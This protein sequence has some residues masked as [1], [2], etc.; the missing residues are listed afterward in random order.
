M[1]YQNFA[2]ELAALPDGRYRISVSSPGGEASA[3]VASPFTDSA[4]SDVLRIL[5]REDDGVTRDEMQQAARAFGEQLFDFLFRTSTAINNAYVASL[6]RAGNEGLRI[7]LSVERA[8]VLSHLPW[9]LIR[10][11]QLEYLSLSR[12]TPVVRYT[13]QLSIRPPAAI[14][15]PLRALVMISSPHDHPPL[16]VEG[17]WTRLKGA[18]AELQRRGI[19]QLERLDNATLIDLQRR[20]RTGDYQ[21][22]HFIGHSD[23][24]PV[25]QQGVLVFEDPNDLNKGQ[26]ITGS[27]L[28][29]ELGEEAPLQLVILNS[30]RSARRVDQDPF[31][32]IASGI[33]ARGIPA[34][35]A[36]QFEITDR[37][38]KVFAEEFYRAI[39][40]LLPI[41]SAVS[42]GRR[43][44]ANVVGN[45][46]W[47]TPVLYM[48]SQTGVLFQNNE[49][50]ASVTPVIPRPTGNRL[51]PVILIALAA[52]LVVVGVLLANDQARLIQQN[53]TATAVVSAATQNA[54]QTLTAQPTIT[55]TLNPAALPDLQISSSRIRIFPQPVTP[56]AFF[57]VNLTIT[58]S[59]SSP[60]GPFEWSWDADLT[61]QRVQQDTVTGQVDNILPGSSRTVSFSYL[62]GW[63]GDYTTQI[64]IDVDEQVPESNNRN[65]EAVFPINVERVPFHIDFTIL[66]DLSIVEPPLILGSDEF[67]PWSVQF[68][69]ATEADPVCFDTPLQLIDLDGD[70]VLTNQGISAACADAPLTIM[71]E[72][73]FVSDALIELIPATTG[74]AAV[75]YFRS[76]T[77]DEPFFVTPAVTLTP[78]T[79]ITL[80]GVGEAGGEIRR[81]EI[82][83][84][85]QPVQLTRLTL[86]PP[87]G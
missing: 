59:G 5:G 67:I 4:I 16:D 87:P 40:E 56:G 85:S 51:L 46:E 34:V 53:Q 23:F 47:A 77:D 32:G 64:Q 10:D 39:A 33:V 52:L 11:P 61:S 74:E 72:R 18:T 9:E 42:E 86:L 2:V 38:A 21:I 1:K 66:P 70:I 20:L 19:L 75:A 36:M 35:V 41:D 7:R 30:C 80:G 84:T 69:V 45:T 24:D 63:W 57:R 26:I 58:N 25:T 13:Q 12:T 71:I 14:T 62:Y 82:R 78:G 37:A 6:A 43:A 49:Q 28:S 55:P 68:S 73:R 22:F 44:I 83:T 60:S 48:R 65:N 29:R 15:F 79:A 27:S 50:S 81:I 54:A 17:E 76:Q 8:G 3:D 31:L